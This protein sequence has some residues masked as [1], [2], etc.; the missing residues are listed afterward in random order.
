MI[1]AIKGTSPTRAALLLLLLI[2]TIIALWVGGEVRTFAHY[3]PDFDEAVHLLPVVEVANA[4]QRGD[5]IGFWQATSRQEQL[6]AYPFV[7]SW[8]AA[9]VWLLRP[10]LTPQRWFSLLCLVGSILLAF[11]ISQTLAT[12]WRWLAGLVGGGLLLASFP[13]WLYGSLAYLEGAGLLL[14]MLAIACYL[15]ANDQQS[16]WL[17]AA[18]VATAATFLTKYNFGL[19]L[20]AAI[21]LN[22]AIG[23]LLTRSTRPPWGRWLRLGAPAAL[24]LLLWF[25][26]PGRLDRFLYF[27]QAQEGQM[28]FW[29]VASWL[30]YPHSFYAHYL[31]GPAAL[32]PVVGGL[33]LALRRWQDGRFRFLLLYLLLSWLMLVIVPQKAPR[34]LYTVA[35]AAL[36]LGG[37]FAAWLYDRVMAQARRVRL[38]VLLLLAGW[39]VWWGTAVAHQFSYLR[40]GLDIIF[41]SV[42]A[43]AT[44]YEWV[45][46]Q[47]LAQDGAVYIPNDWHLFN[48]YSLQWQHLASQGYPATPLDLSRVRGGPAPE[49]TAANLE[50]L[51]VRWQAQGIDYVL[52]IDGSPAGSYAGW[53]VVEPLLGQGHLQPVASSDSLTLRNWDEQY[54]ERV[55]A[56]DFAGR[57]EWAQW[58]RQRRGEY[59]IR[60]H[61]Y[62]VIGENQ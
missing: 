34:F 13:L 37:P 57:D 4:I 61:L 10:G 45:N 46:R 55:L 5:L 21:G 18:S 9:P 48:V 59:E 19:F 11:V 44:G 14:T 12:R 1:P 60:L 2:S 8:L 23:W 39:L 28:D 51:L 38:A 40:P 58:E 32:L 35:P 49:P 43:T 42:P 20:V 54:R 50:Q 56:A 47:T 30:Y 36:V 15:R 7:H 31:A 6:A 29:Q 17:I 25:A 33:V 27:G 52:S 16:R 26:A 24:I 41:D 62:R 53:A 22:E 3:P